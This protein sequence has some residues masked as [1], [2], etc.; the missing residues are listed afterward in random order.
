MKQRLI[1]L[2]VAITSVIAVPAF[3]ETYPVFDSFGYGSIGLGPFPAPIPTYGLGFRTQS[4]HHGGDFSL[5]GSTI[6]VATQIKTN[7]LY[8]YYPEPSYVSQFYVGGGIGPSWVFADRDRLFLLSPEIVL[9]QQYRN[10]ANNIRFYQ[11]QISFPTFVL[12]RDGRRHNEVF[13]YPL[14]VFSYGFGF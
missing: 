7:L 9:G 5:Q 14:V 13:K 4:G 11:A 3:A 2:L 10:V 1:A 8:H 6:V 12:K